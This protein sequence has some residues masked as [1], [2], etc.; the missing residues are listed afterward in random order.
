M[1]HAPSP[2]STTELHPRRLA[3]AMIRCEA[4]ASASPAFSYRIVPVVEVRGEII[5][6]CTT[7][8]H[9]PGLAAES[10]GIRA[11]A[12][13][14]CTLGTAI[15]ERISALFAARQPSRALALDIVS[16]ELLFRLAD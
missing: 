16:N 10:G 13:A 8:L 7:T 15:Q 3:P 4:R 2:A 14:A 11:V 9:A 1:M 12:A 5:A 6:V